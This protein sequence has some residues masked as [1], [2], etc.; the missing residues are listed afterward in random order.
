MHWGNIF[1]DYPVST[2]SNV[3]V[4]TYRY[5]CGYYEFDQQYPPQLNGIVDPQ[6]YV[7][8]LADLNIRF[9]EA[10]KAARYASYIPIGGLLVWIIF[11][12]LSI[13]VFYAFY[14][15]FIIFAIFFCSII[16]AS[17]YANN[18]RR[19]VVVKMAPYLTELS[20][21][22]PGT[23]WRINGV[24]FY[25]YTAFWLEI[26]LSHPGVV[27]SMPMGMGGVTGYVPYP[28]T[29]PGMVAS[30][31]YPPGYPTVAPTAGIPPA[32][33]APAYAAPGPS[34]GSGFCP[35]C[36]SLRS[37]APTCQSCGTRF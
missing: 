12:F 34:V 33:T 16:A 27:V 23:T 15:L 24:H 21:K 32:Y 5:G 1:Y 11:V 4:P 3:H 10:M 8:T 22:Y 29:V 14:V 7:N 18:M 31:G 9:N 20:A 19:Q 6:S 30:P 2:P 35:K 17:Q 13:Y 26:I 25:R 36:G 37:G 28:G